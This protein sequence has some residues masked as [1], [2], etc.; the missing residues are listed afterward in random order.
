MKS[1]M[2]APFFSIIVPTYN[3]AGHIG[4]TIQSVLGQQFQ[5]FELIVVDDGSTDNTEVVVREFKDERLLY[6][7][8]ANG[9]RGAAR[10]YGIKRSSGAYVTFLDSD[11]RLYP[12]FFREARNFIKKNNQ[13]EFFHCG[14]EIK[15]EKGKVVT[16]VKSERGNSNLRLAK[17]NFLSCI[18][19]FVRQDIIKKHLFNE[20]RVI[21]GSEDYELWMRIASRYSLVGLNKVTAYMVQHSGRSVINFSESEL[22]ERIELTLES[23]RNDPAVQQFYKEQ[24]NTIYAHQNMYLALH[25]MLKGNKRLAFTY[26]TKAISKDP[27]VIFTRKMAS[28][29]YKGLKI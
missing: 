9:E 23:L 4:Q 21:A 25:L 13:P 27:K 12:N 19:V 5:N 6:L 11:D 18:G 20:E 15:D 1:N 7:K 22:I 17:G 2:K 26:A 14:Y 8:K 10:N 16:R 29:V 28:L 24:L 3:R